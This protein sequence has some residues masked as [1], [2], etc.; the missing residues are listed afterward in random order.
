ML[1]KCK[2]MLL[3]KFWIYYDDFG[4]L[5][6]FWFIII[7]KKKCVMGL[8][9]KFFWLKDVCIKELSFLFVF[10]ILYWNYLRSKKIENIYLSNYLKIMRFVYCYIL[11]ISLINWM[12]CN[13]FF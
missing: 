7:M 2:Y 5:D 9:I 11:N 8:I 13:L 3:I 6:I 12:F 10:E 4:F 1:C